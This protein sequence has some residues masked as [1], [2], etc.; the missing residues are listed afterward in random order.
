VRPAAGLRLLLA[1][2]VAG[3]ALATLGVAR[4]H[5]AGAFAGHSLTGAAVEVAAPLALVAAGVLWA[6]SP[7]RGGWLLVIAAIAWLAPEWANPDIGTAA[8]FTLGLAGSFACA[9]LAVHAAL[10][11]PAGALR[12]P[13]RR[14]V[15]GLAY[16][17]FG[18]LALAPTLFFEPRAEG[19]SACPHNLWLLHTSPSL[20]ADLSRWGIRLAIAWTVLA[21]LTL[22][23]AAARGLVR[24]APVQGAAALYL[25]LASAQLWHDASHGVLTNDAV[26]VALW[27][28]QG[29]ALIVLAL[30]V[31]AGLLH[32]R[33]VRAAMASLV[34]DL[35]HAP[36]I[37]GA[38]D[39]L[40]GALG[41]PALEL[42]FRRESRDGF[43]DLTGAPRSPAGGPGR[44]ATPLVRDGEV[45]ALVLHDQRYLAEPAVLQE[46]IGAARLAIDNDRLQAELR[47]QAA[48]IRAS[49]A[50]IVHEG[51]SERR[52][53]EHDLH[54]G[55]Q[56][57]LVALS[58]GLR[59]LRGYAEA[60]AALATL[61]QADAELQA[62]VAELREVAHGIYPAALR[63]DGLG[64]AV[65]ALAERSP[66][67]L[68]IRALPDGRFPATVEEAAYFTTAEFLRDVG[69]N[70][71]R[72]AVAQADGELI[73]EIE[74]NG[75]VEHLAE[76]V[77]RIADR[78][79]A[80]DG[81]VEVVALPHG[82]A[83]LRAGIPC[84]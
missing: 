51:D 50:R 58:L 82:G 60:P 22:A 62:A 83:R 48:D 61:D 47:A 37:G 5:P 15:V 24:T 44:A 14:I 25:G 4:A 20:H 35:G 65:E 29:A 66:A 10:A 57:R 19:C 17:G 1:A 42:A 11:H 63:S 38:R 8:L 6:G 36:R 32:A 21:A 78:V 18:L 49:R 46:T 31:I 77:T 73:V 28:G 16:A 67:G 56:Q 74:R 69:S 71:A 53:L 45:V 9:P 72:V 41:D 7:V 23:A 12:Q 79:G 59:L 84:A 68:R 2:A 70:P 76:R 81:R 54:D 33:R 80:L 55:A 27:K 52:R 64:A 30:A 13:G 43:V 39:M 3:A 26:D 40:A 75:T 34:V